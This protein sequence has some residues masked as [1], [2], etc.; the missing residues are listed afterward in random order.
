MEKSKNAILE[1]DLMILEEK[2][3]AGKA[4]YTQTLKTFHEKIAKFKNL[5]NLILEEKTK[6]EKLFLENK[7]MQVEMR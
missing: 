6:S 4:K 3:E 7:S 2:L 5:Q 1:N